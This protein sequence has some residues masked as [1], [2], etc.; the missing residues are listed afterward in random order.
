MRLLRPLF[1]LL[2][3]LLFRCPA[4]CQNYCPFPGQSA[5]SAIPICGTAVFSQT[6]AAQPWSY[7]FDYM[8][9]CPSAS[10]YKDWNAFWYK[11]NCYQSGTLAFEIKPNDLTDDYDWAI[12]DIT[13]HQPDDVYTLPGL[14]VACNWTG[15]RGITGASA[16]GVDLYTCYSPSA[17]VFGAMPTLQ[18]GH[19]YLLMVANF[20]QSPFGY[21]LSFSG[22]TAVITDAVLPA[23]VNA[24]YDEN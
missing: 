4:F 15:A 3:P 10:T 18:Q 16:A 5:H 8:T 17:P 22:G 6:Q 23:I 13:G 24:W 14:V 20:S 7:K 9:T 19:E 12:F 21:D 2:C 1:L 11:F